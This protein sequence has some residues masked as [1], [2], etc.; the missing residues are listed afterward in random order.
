MKKNGEKQETWCS[1]ENMQAWLVYT[2]R[3][4]FRVCCW[5]SRSF[6]MSEGMG[7]EMPTHSDGF[8]HVP[9]HQNSR[10][11]VASKQAAWGIAQKHQTSSSSHEHFR[12]AASQDAGPP[13]ACS[14]AWPLLIWPC[15]NIA[16]KAE[17]QHEA[18]AWLHCDKKYKK[19]EPSNT[20]KNEIMLGMLQKIK[21]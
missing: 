10:A 17:V 2:S 5:C 20:S 8:A 6:S 3:I 11:L 16:Q 21:K 1:E 4:S 7:L 18:A 14:F 12:T 13:H 9:D 19:L 15:R